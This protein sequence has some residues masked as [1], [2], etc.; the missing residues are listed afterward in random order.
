MSP[1]DGNQGLGPYVDT[2]PDQLYSDDDGNLNPHASDTLPTPPVTNEKGYISYRGSEQHGVRFLPDSEGPTRTNKYAAEQQA[3]ETYTNPN[4]T[5]RDIVPVRPLAVEI[6]DT[7]NLLHRRVARG[8]T[9]GFAS[10]DTDWHQILQ[11][12]PFRKRVI[13]RA[14]TTGGFYI[15]ALSPE[16]TPNDMT[17][18]EVSGTSG[19]EVLDTT[20]TSPFAIRVLGGDG[21]LRISVWTEYLMYD[22]ERILDGG[23]ATAGGNG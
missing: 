15:F 22:G 21:T 16:Q 19:I 9:Y 4:I 18:I 20:S 14:R 2:A 17:A 8:T 10:T 1:A 23:Y 7:P 11:A 5:P 12:D 6:V 13:I 3:F